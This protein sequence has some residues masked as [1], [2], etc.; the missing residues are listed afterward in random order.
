MSR[1]HEDPQ[2]VR[3]V[4]VERHRGDVRKP[5]EPLVDLRLVE[6][7]QTAA[8]ERL[9]SLLDVCGDA[10]RRAGDLDRPQGEEGRLA[11]ANQTI[12][13]FKGENVWTTALLPLLEELHISEWAL[14]DE[15][16]AFRQ[17]HHPTEH[18]KFV[19]K[20]ARRN[21]IL[22]GISAAVQRTP[23]AAPQADS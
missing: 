17:F 5:C 13:F 7:E 19:W 3:E 20:W 2:G 12:F 18:C 22:K 6:R 15:H 14:A 23:A 21:S 16:L 9:E 10:G 11:C 1:R 8:V 4:A